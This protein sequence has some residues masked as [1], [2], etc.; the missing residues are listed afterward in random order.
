MSKLF[1]SNTQK[2]QSL[3]TFKANAAAVQARESIQKITG[4]ALSGCHTGKLA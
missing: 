4:G 3:E 2:R 1:S